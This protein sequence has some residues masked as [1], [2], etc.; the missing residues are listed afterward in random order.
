MHCVVLRRQRARGRLVVV[1]RSLLAT[2]SLLVS[3]VLAN[4]QALHPQGSCIVTSSRAKAVSCWDL[5]ALQLARAATPTPAAA[6]PAGGAGDV[7]R[8][9]LQLEA[10]SGSVVVCVRFL[11]GERCRLSVVLCTGWALVRPGASHTTSRN[12]SDTTSPCCR[13]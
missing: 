2:P 8:T 1:D 10:V 6:R 12:S 4:L 5:T 11:T 7:T 9:Q 13:H 3:P